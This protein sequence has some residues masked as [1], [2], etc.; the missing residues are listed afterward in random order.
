MTI[1]DGEAN[2]EY[3]FKGGV[4]GTGVVDKGVDYRIFFPIL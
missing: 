1:Y 3:S 2:I 4:E